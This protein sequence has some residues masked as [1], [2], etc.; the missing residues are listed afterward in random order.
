MARPGHW[1][2]EALTAPDNPLLD[3]NQAARYLL[4]KPRTL[5]LWRR[6]RGLPHIKITH[7]V[8]RYRKSDLD[9]WLARRRIA[10]AA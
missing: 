10:I 7:K 1:Q 9:A 4:T 2:G 6:T 3:D 8:I 5:R